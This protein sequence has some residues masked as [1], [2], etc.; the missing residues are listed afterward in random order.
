MFKYQLKLHTNYNINYS[1][2]IRTRIGDLVQFTNLSIIKVCYLS[3]RNLKICV[4]LALLLAVIVLSYKSYV[5]SDT[6]KEPSISFRFDNI[7]SY[8][9]SW[10][11]TW[12]PCS[13]LSHPS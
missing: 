11:P 10:I 6:G 3:L 7:F 9:R 8:L 12:D 13:N 2:Y 1:G 5:Q 4:V